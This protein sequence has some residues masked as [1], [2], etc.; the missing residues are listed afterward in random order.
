MID[1]GRGITCDPFA[2]SI[3]SLDNKISYGLSNISERLRFEYGEESKIQFIDTN[4]N[5]THVEVIIK[6]KNNADTE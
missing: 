2:T 1:N 3:H 5:G 4:G 6:Y